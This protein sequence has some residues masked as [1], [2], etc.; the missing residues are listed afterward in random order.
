MKFMRPIIIGLLLNIL[1]VVYAQP[2]IEVIY[3]KP[4][5]IVYP[6]QADINF[7]RD[8]MIEVQAFFALEMQRHGF[9]PKTFAFDPKIKVVSGKQKAEYYDNAE[10]LENEVFELDH[11]VQNKI[12][13][14]F[15]AGKRDIHN[16]TASGVMK[17]FCWHWPGANQQ[18][19][20]CNYLVIIPIER[21]D[22][23]L[24]STA[25]EIAHAFKIS[26]SPNNVGDG[27]INLMNVPHNVQHGV[28][29]TLDKYG[30]RYADAA[31]LNESGRLSI[32]EL[33]KPSHQNIQADVNNDGYIDLAD[34]MIVRNG[35][36]NFVPYNT[37]VNNDGITDEIDLLIVKAKAHE[38]ITAAAPALRRRKLT[39]WAETKRR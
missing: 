5:D 8:I 9:E 14:V 10:S 15:L 38:A 28:K 16:K 12:A 18:P 22:Y 23:L 31:F 13:V 21:K 24:P 11:S 36:Q 34:V 20:D 32:Q 39:T 27:R 25:H 2:P 4:S 26:H 17:F 7:V 1:L 30:I 29:E 19:D 3:L 35:I 6:S 33:I 37:D